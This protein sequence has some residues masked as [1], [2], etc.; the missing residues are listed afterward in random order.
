MKHT[1]IHWMMPI[2]KSI[3]ALQKV[4]KISTAMTA[5]DVYN[6]VSVMDKTQIAK[7]ARSLVSE[8]TVN[9]ATISKTD[10]AQQQ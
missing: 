8:I 4:L 3:V 2:R 1:I 10:T 9:N 7:L 5:E 6:A